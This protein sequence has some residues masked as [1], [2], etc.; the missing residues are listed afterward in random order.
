MT[1]S[2]LPPAW[3]IYHGQGGEPRPDVTIPAPP[4]WRT[5][6][7]PPEKSDR[8]RS[9]KDH[10]RRGNGGWLPSTESIRAKRG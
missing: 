4:P 2:S 6:D 3:W 1:S 7:R 10:I 5:F 8:V 9:M